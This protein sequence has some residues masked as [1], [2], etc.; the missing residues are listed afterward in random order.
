MNTFFNHFYL[1][2]NGVKQS[3][4]AQFQIGGLGTP[5]TLSFLSLMIIL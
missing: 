3:L 1:N 5:N 4:G 2:N